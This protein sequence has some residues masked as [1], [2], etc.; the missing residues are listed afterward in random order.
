MLSCCP[1]LLQGLLNFIQRSGQGFSVIWWW[2]RAWLLN[3]GWQQGNMVTGREENLE[4]AEGVM[5]NEMDQLRGKGLDK[6]SS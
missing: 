5:R 6:M 2:I 1:E 4:K 3:N